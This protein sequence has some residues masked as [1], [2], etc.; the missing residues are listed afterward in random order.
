MG[1]DIK[2]VLFDLDGTVMDTSEGILVSIK[3]TIIHFGYEMLPDSELCT[4]IGP[5]IEW[6]FEEKLG[7]PKEKIKEVAAYFRDRYSNHNLLLATPYEGMFE[8]LKFLT[9]KNQVFVLF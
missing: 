3:D 9:L 8:F 4:F 1:Y 6:S 2:A 7:V 5:P